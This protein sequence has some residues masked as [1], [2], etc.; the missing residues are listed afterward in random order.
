MLSHFFNSNEQII[1]NGDDCSI[2]F[3]GFRCTDS[4][5]SGFGWAKISGISDPGVNQDPI[6]FQPLFISQVDW[7]VL[8]FFSFFLV[9]I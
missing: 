7:Q 4:N 1:R 6:I 3:Y 9:I 8:T 5:H 2:F